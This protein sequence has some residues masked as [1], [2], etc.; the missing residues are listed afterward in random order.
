MKEWQDVSVSVDFRLPAANVMACVGT[1][2]DQM[3]V[4]GVVMCIKSSGAWQLTPWRP[5]AQR[6]CRSVALDRQGD[7][8]TRSGH[9]W[10]AHA[11][12]HDGRHVDRP[13]L[14]DGESL[15]QGEQLKTI[16]GADTGL[17]LRL[18]PTPGRRLSSTT[19]VCMPG[20]PAMACG[21][22]AEP[23]HALRGSDAHHAPLPNKRPDGERSRL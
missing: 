11:E 4:E 8:H 15:W 6:Q 10:V 23:M 20:R 2:A 21:G 3:W 19:F 1:R 5:R 14:L 22:G 16:R 7:G 13:P 18:G 9:Y 12:R 17:S